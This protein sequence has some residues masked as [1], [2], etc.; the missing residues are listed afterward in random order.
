MLAIL[1]KKKRLLRKTA[2]RGRSQ[3]RLDKVALAGIAL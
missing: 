1:L 3:A 2:S